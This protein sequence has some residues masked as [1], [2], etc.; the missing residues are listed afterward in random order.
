MSKSVFSKT[1]TKKKKKITKTVMIS[2]DDVASRTRSPSLLK[3]K[4][5]R[6]VKQ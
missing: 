6:F 5:I 4:K 3:K 2:D 1:K